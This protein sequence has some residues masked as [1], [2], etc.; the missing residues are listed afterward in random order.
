[1]IKGVKMDNIEAKRLL[2][3]HGVLVE[4]D[5]RPYAEIARALGYLPT[6]QAIEVKE[7][8]IQVE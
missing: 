5:K 4:A 2:E 3:E 6:E 7:V 8:N 1:L